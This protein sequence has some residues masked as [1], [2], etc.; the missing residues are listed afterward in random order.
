[1]IANSYRIHHTMLTHQA[2]QANGVF[3][4]QIG[5][6]ARCLQPGYGQR[7]AQRIPSWVSRSNYYLK[8]CMAPIQCDTYK[9][10]SVELN[11][12]PI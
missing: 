10:F 5:L 6:R 1:M 4:G 3:A 9:L 7:G 12:D 8:K 2:S 11:E